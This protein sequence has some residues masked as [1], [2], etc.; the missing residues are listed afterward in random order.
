M[1]ALTE[2]WTKNKV[3]ILGLIGAVVYAIMTIDTSVEITWTSMV[4]PAIIAIGSYIG[5]NTKGQLTTVIGIGIT[6]FIG[7]MQSKD[8]T[9]HH[10]NSAELAQYVIMQLGVL[11]FGFAAP[12][13]K[14]KDPKPAVEDEPSEPAK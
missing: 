1:K 10:L 11:Y 8:E 13:P 7:Y 12:T 9:G 3:F 4:M 14:N 6:I 5:R 2:F